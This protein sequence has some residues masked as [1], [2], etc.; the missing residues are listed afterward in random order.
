MR[1]EPKEKIKPYH[2]ILL[3]C[4][5][6][7]LM[8]LN[9]NYVNNQKQEFKSKKQSEQY[10]SEM[11]NIRRLSGENSNTEEVCSR[12]ADDLINYYK[13][14][15]LSKIDLDN[16]PIKCEDK[17]KSYMKTLI[18]IVRE[19][20]GDSSSSINDNSRLRNLGGS[21][22]TNKLVDYLMRT[23][24]FLIFLVFGV[25]SIFGWIVC[26]ICCCCD[27]CC[28]CCC[29]KESCK[30]P[31][32][33]FTF[34]FYALS[35]ALSIY[36]LS[37]SKK[38]FVGLANTE[39]SIL[40]FFGQVLDGEIK[41]ERPRWAGID[42]IKNLLDRLISEIQG[43]RSSAI[44][45]LENGIN[46][47]KNAKYEFHTKMKEAGDKFFTDQNY[48]AYITKYSIN[49]GNKDIEG[50]PLEDNYILDVVKDF[51]YQPNVVI[52]G[53]T[54]DISYIPI[55]STLYKWN[56]EYSIVSRNAD[57]YMSSA[58]SSFINILTGDNYYE[59]INSLNS[60]KTNLDKLTKPFT[61]AEKEFG[62]LLGDYS[63]HIDKYGKMSVTIVFSVLM[64]INIAL[65]VLMLLIYFFSSKACA[66]CC[67][68][69]CLFKFCTHI[70][71]NVLS[72]MIIL[73]FIIGA[74]LG[75]VGTIGGDMMSLVSYIMSEENF[76]SNTPLLLNKLG[77]SQRY[78]RRC[79]HGDGK[80]AEELG[81]DNSMDSFENINSV[82]LQINDAISEFEEIQD[83]C[84]TY[85]DRFEKLEREKNIDGS[86][87][88]IPFRGEANDRKVI[89]YDEILEKLNDAVSGY[90]NWDAQTSN[91]DSCNSDSLTQITYFKPKNCKPYDNPQITGQSS[92]FEKYAQILKNIDTM[93]NN[94]NDETEDV[95]DSVINVIKTLK[96]HY[97]TFL[98]AYTRE[99]NGFLGIIH[100][101]TNLVRRYSGDNDLF[102]FLNGKFIGTNL[103]IIL[104]YLKY[105]LG[106]D[107]Y[108]VGV[109][110]IVVGCSL[111]LS[112]SSTIIL[113]VIINIE[114]KKN[115]DAKNL[116]NTGMVP[117]YQQNYPQQV[118]SYNENKI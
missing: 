109:C 1:K 38:I 17:D 61:D 26:C 71:W 50:Y 57:G 4:L 81:L 113:I 51:G 103:K 92:L 20:A 28:C 95:G 49:Y 14:G 55:G 111:A 63:G 78:I 75:L 54:D 100:Q 62:T 16:E 21:L 105:S 82:E 77:D 107:L 59:V 30:V 66:G 87:Q 44:E 94:A 11:M 96:G 2:I 10:F 117:E 52:N 110:L 46:E 9:S 89:K 36:G 67:C 108:T 47:I 91:D 18:D 29:K 53:E 69:R 27:C 106:V 39:C 70:L 98:R 34:V 64:V 12:A 104:K 76:N 40:K 15:D 56:E 25:L 41:Q 115:Q 83:Q 24:P 3:S 8:I 99:L 65:A 118:I 72:L 85:Q 33:I 19:M 79:I 86:T 116:A 114:L 37:Q 73:S 60:G 31:C 102:S 90:I 74:I 5:L 13:T 42:G 84:L 7:S 58:K 80:I 93:V 35:V 97:E 43:M 6:A 32:F 88:L 68:M 48:I 22:D 45:A 112:V 101:I 23:I